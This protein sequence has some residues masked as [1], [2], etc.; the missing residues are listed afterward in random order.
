MAAAGRHGRAL[1]VN[2]D[3][4]KTKVTFRPLIGFR[5]FQQAHR[6]RV[7]PRR[8]VLRANATIFCRYLPVERTGNGYRRG[9][10]YLIFASA[11]LRV[12]PARPQRVLRAARGERSVQA[13]MKLVAVP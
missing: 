2:E 4:A 11:S 12:E 3:R 9:R 6:K 10:R 13:P 7:V 5:K 1:K 8:S